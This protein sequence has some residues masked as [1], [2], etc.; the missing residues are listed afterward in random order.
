MGINKTLVDLDF[1]WTIV[2]HPFGTG[3]ALVVSRGISCEGH[4]HAITS[5]CNT[6]EDLE[7]AV[8]KIVEKNKDEIKKAIDGFIAMQ[9]SLFA[10][11]Y[12][13]MRGYK[14]SLS[15]I[16]MQSLADWLVHEA[17]EMEREEFR[18]KYNQSKEL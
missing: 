16:F 12:D 15:A 6:V 18:L 11:N 9:N 17:Q 4:Y 10:L 7:G 1:N 5:H 8:K 2:Y 13:F 3:I 14:E